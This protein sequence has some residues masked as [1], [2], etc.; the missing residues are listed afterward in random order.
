MDTIRTCK[1]CNLSINDGIKFQGPYRKVCTRCNSKMSNERTKMK[2][3][4]YFREK[5]KQCY[6]Y[7]GKRGRPKKCQELNL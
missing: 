2:D 3:P 5:M 6:V 1:E 7:H 4:S